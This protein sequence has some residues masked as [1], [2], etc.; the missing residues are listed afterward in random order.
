MNHLSD[1][2]LIALIINKSN[3]KAFEIIY[4]R[5]NKKL[6]WFSRQLIGN[7]EEAE[8]IVHD[9][10]IKII[11]QAK[12]YDNNY[13]FS[14]WIYAIVKNASLATLRK[15]NYR[16]ELLKEN[17]TIN[18]VAHLNITI[19]SKKMREQV[20]QLFQTLSEKEQLI[21]ILRI[22]LNLSLNEIADIAEIPLGSVKSC[23]YYLLKK[24]S[25]LKSNA[26]PS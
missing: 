13:K 11:N 8:D 6:I 18:E 3:E 19:D 5:Y 24:F 7:L 2:A 4:E 23:L 14:T 9:T 1:E 20:N 22:E 15:T 25:T 26:N 12:G 10:F 21:F 16:N 17:Y